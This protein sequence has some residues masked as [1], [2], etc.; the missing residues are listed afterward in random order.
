M[1]TPALFSPTVVGRMH[2]AH[3]VVLAPM[4]R[5]R[6]NP[7][8][9]VPLSLVKEFYE[10]RAE[11]QGTFLI[12]DGMVVHEKAGGIPAVA[13]LYTDEQVSAWKE[14]SPQAILHR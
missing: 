11:I 7:Q 13:A 12:A 14:V 5:M 1:S 10:Q 8:T 3:R 6:N 9:F 2:L 4:T